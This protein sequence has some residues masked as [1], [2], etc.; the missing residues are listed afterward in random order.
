MSLNYV[1]PNPLEPRHKTKTFPLTPSP[2]LIRGVHQ[3]LLPYSHH[4][5]MQ[6]RHLLRV[7]ELQRELLLMVVIWSLAASYVTHIEEEQGV[8]REYVEER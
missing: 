4:L 8:E 1:S 2:K 5:K 6:V 3:N 7:V